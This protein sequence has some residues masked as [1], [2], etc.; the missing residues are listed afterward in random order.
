MIKFISAH[1]KFLSYL[2]MWGLVSCWNV[3]ERTVIQKKKLSSLLGKKSSEGLKGHLSSTPSRI[4]HLFSLG[5]TSFNH[6]MVRWPPD[7]S[8]IFFFLLHHAACGILVPWPG[9]EPMPPALQAWSLN[10]WT[11]R[12]VLR[13]IALLRPPMGLHFCFFW[14]NSSH[15]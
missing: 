1:I 4:R 15:A 5:L 9:I 12:E 10:H 7:C 13:V 14:S 3:Q 11:T 8:V 2:I 6:S